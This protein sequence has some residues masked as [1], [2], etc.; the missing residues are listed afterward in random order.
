ME[1]KT[2]LLVTG[3][4]KWLKEIVLERLKRIRLPALCH[5]KHVQEK[6]S[7][8]TAVKYKTDT[9]H[10]LHV[11]FSEF[12]KAL[13]CETSSRKRKRSHSYEFGINSNSKMIMNFFNTALLT[14]TIAQVCYPINGCYV[15]PPGKK[16]PCD[17][18]ICE[19]G[20]ICVSSSDGLK[21]R[22]QCP[23]E[24]NSYGDSVGSTPVCGSDGQDYANWCELRL[25]ACKTMTEIKVKY[26]GKCSKCLHI[27]K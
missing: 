11:R 13:Y 25:A 6:H 23:Q 19:V 21:A 9:S 10:N 17:G 7:T 2:K 1:D 26:Y 15:F 20:A 5:W 12:G 14:I 22:C 3:K 4:C 24:C 27:I 8:R 18:W 16:D